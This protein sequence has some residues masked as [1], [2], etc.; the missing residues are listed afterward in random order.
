MKDEYILWCQILGRRKFCILVG[1]CIALLSFKVEGAPHNIK[2]QS[3]YDMVEGMETIESAKKRVHNIALQQAI[4]QAGVYVESYT[5]TSNFQLVSDEVNVIAGSNLKVLNENYVIQSIDDIYKRIICDVT[6]S[7]DNENIDLKARMQDKKALEE[8]AYQY[9]LLQQKN[10]ELMSEN[11]LLK[12]QFKKERGTDKESVIIHEFEKNRLDLELNDNLVEANVLIDKKNYTDAVEL[13]D[14]LIGEFSD[15]DEVY[16]LRGVV[17]YRKNMYS[18]AIEYFNKAIAINPSNVWY[19][20]NRAMSYMGDNQYLEG[21]EDINK[22]IGFGDKTACLY[23]NRG[24]LNSS[25]G[26]T[27]RAI[28]DFST[29]IMMDESYADAYCDRGTE[30]LKIGDYNAALND[31][32]RAVSINPNDPNTWCNRGTVFYLQKNYTKAFD[33]YTRCLNLKPDIV[34]AYHNRGIS[35]FCLGRY[36]EA[37]VDFDLR[38]HLEPNSVAYL[39]KGMCS[40]NLGNIAEAIESFDESIRLNNNNLRAH[41]FKA[42]LCYGLKRFEDAKKEYMEVL[43]INPTNK[44]A[45]TYLRLME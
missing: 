38:N 17:S 25:L 35:L 27:T 24:H 2:V 18:E 34:I 26:N 14:R 19:Y 41:L 33:D 9:S 4:E 15:S 36:S 1:V 12:T 43:R 7:I 6:V 3:S 45:R 20:N 10:N 29:A 8:A 16:N 42:E 40:A 30:Y 13:L 37:I 31:F 21:I 11:E 28:E 32:E 23:L 22:A 5:K 39:T 44:K